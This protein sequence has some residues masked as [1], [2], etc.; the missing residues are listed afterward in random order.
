MRVFHGLQAF[1]GLALG[2]LLI[3]LTAEAQELPQKA[4][5]VKSLEPVPVRSTEAIKT[6]GGR[7]IVI[8]NPMLDEESSAKTN[9]LQ[10]YLMPEDLIDQMTNRWDFQLQEFAIR[11]SYNTHS[12]DSR[13]SRSTS[14]S[15]AEEQK[16]RENMAS[17]MKRYMV[18]K[19][20]PKYLTTK[21]STRFI[22]EQYIKAEAMV[23][24]AGRVEFKGKDESW[25][26]GTGIN[27]FTTKAW[28]KYSNPTSSVELYNIFEKK[29]SL[30]IAFFTQRGRYIPN[31]GYLIQKNS[32]ITGTKFRYSRVLE[33]ELKSAWPLYK[34]DLLNN[35]VTS[36]SSTYRF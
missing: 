19:G 8:A 4:S 7:S 18:R 15:P 26:F 23:Q 21:K 27:P 29:N 13:L 9:D 11:Q 14:G 31:A 2:T 20:L 12:R 35:T 28:L 16:V 17:F 33:Y 10:T 1:R 22:G 34:G 30:G 24:R 5:S 32:F 36:V 3:G 6:R 25:K